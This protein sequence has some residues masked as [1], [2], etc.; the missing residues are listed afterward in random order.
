MQRESVK[1]SR[2]AIS[3]IY[4]YSKFDMTYT[5]IHMPAYLESSYWEHEDASLK[6]SCNSVG[7]RK[8]IQSVLFLDVPGSPSSGFQRGFTSVDVFGCSLMTAG[9][10]VKFRRITRWEDLNLG[11]YKFSPSERRLHEAVEQEQHTVCPFLSNDVDKSQTG[12]LPVLL[13][14]SGARFGA[15]IVVSPNLATQD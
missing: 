9:V 7:V 1:T 6:A 12:L 14:F 4:R 8:G 3:G 5:L 11:Q 2:G 15:F 13:S 10:P